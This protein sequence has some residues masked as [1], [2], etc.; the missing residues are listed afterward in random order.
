MKQE[1]EK[2]MSWNECKKLPWDLILFL[3]ASFAIADGVQ[4]SGLANVLSRVLDFLHDTPHWAIVPAVSLVCS[5]I[6]EFITSNAATAT[7]LVPLLYHLAMTMHVHPLLLMIPGGIATE[8]AFCLPTSTPSNALGFA[9]GHIEI[10]DML[11][12]GVPLKVVGIVV[13]SLLM[14]SLDNLKIE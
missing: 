13:L 1:G 12:V 4:S 2:L 6:T 8:F 5:I 9:T 10:K 3:G 11:K 7:L 14:P